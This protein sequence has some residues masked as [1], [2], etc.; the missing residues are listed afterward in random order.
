M[1]VSDHWHSSFSLETLRRRLRSVP[2]L[3]SLVPLSLGILAESCV[4]LAE[5]V[6]VLLFVVTLG[7]ALWLRSSMLRLSFVAATLLFAGWLV[8]D[9]R[10]V[11]SS[12]PRDYEVD[13]VVRLDGVRERRDSYSSCSGVVEAWRGDEGWQSA[14]SPV[15][16]RLWDETIVEGD[17]L[18]LRGKIRSR[19]S[20]VENYD[21]LMHYR[22][23]EGRV[24]LHKG[25]YKRL[26]S[27]DGESL[28][29]R[30]VRRLERHLRDSSAY[31]TAEAMV[32][33]SRRLIDQELRDSY[34][35]TGLTHLMAVSGLHL[36]IIMLVVG[37]MLLPINLLFWG[38]QMRAVLIIVVLW[39]FAAVSGFSPSV[40]RS[41]LMFTVLEVS[42]ATVGRYSSM[43]TL[44]VVILVMLVANPNYLFDLSFQLSVVAVVGIVMWGVPMLSYLARHQVAGS[45]FLATVVISL[46]ATLWTMP[47]VAYMFEDVSFMSIIVSPLVLFTAYAIVGFGVFA[48]LLPDGLA[49]P[50][51]R[52]MEFAA[53]LQNSIAERAYDTGYGVLDGELQ[54]WVVVVVYLIFMAITL[55]GCSWEEKKMVTLSFDE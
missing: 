38:W 18:L 52:V 53:K 33:G 42:L 11:E 14:S 22:G 43:N 54:G 3:L 50:F 7:G 29:V 35:R 36:G 47:L 45:R 9:V 49:M 44:S 12:L 6:V 27:E 37:V 19:I 21:R 48:L 1:S 5:W 8:A 20:S 16:L 17:R 40:V 51:G 28:H 39:L 13:I 30:S 10:G 26:Q 4:E 32:V 55:V 46:V 2:A 31:A 24:D 41:A 25:A 34:S 15:V 23:Y